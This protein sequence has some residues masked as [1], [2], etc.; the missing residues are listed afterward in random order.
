MC[1]AFDFNVGCSS[2]HTR[3]I[4]ALTFCEH[5][6]LIK[7]SFSILSLKGA[8]LQRVQVNAPTHLKK[9]S[10]GWIIVDA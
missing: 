2:G 4:A 1:I 10:R 8:Q 6:S 9:A 3:N 5:I 7:I